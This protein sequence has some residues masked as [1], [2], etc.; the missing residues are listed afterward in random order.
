LSLRFNTVFVGLLALAFLSAFVLPAEL[1]NRLRGTQAVFAPV[2]RPTRAVASAARNRIASK[3]HND[4]RDAGVVKDENERLRVLVMSLSGQLDELKRVANDLDRLGDVREHC[5]RFKVIGG[6]GDGSTRD[7][8]ILAASTSD[9]VKESQPVITGQGMVGMIER[10]GQ[11]GA[12]VRL[13]TD[14]DFKVSGR[15][16]RFDTKSPTGELTLPTKIPLVR[17]T[18][19]GVLIVD[20]IEIKETALSG[21]PL[22]EKVAVGDY[23]KLADPLWPPNLSGKMLGRV[24]A[25]TQQSGA[26]QHAMIRIK[27]LL[28]LTQLREVMVMNKLELNVAQPA[29]ATEKRAAAGVN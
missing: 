26:P 23:V 9:G 3:P 21:E 17:G 4:T 14:R 16:V 29:S 20:N 7:S 12:Q 25:I 11:A 8:L 10:V 19:N 15:F 18:G 28:D 22:L 2:S 1:G 5:T 13:I 24:E 6:G 27:P